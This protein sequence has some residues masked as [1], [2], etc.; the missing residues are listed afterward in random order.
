MEK[1]FLSYTYRPH[2]DHAEETERLQRYARRV[3]EAMGLRVIDGVDLGG[4]ALD[5]ALKERISDA[6]ALIAL[7]TP[8]ADQANQI[9]EPQFV[10]SEF[11]FADARQKPTLRI[12]H[13]ALQPRGLGAANEYFSFAAGRELDVVFKLMNTLAIWKRELG[14]AV[15]LR[16]EPQ[17]VAGRYDE[18]QGHEC[19]YQRI[20]TRGMEP[21][22]RAIVL[23]EP[24]AAYVYL[25]KIRTGE[26]VRVR[27]EVDG[28]RWLSKTPVD[29]FVGGISIEREP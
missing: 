20:T 28:E 12:I 7:M 27:L 24:G 14:E 1:V 17:D 2:P 15:R 22:Q 21:W 16:L 11:T 5:D 13:Q 26:R 19:E 23:A 29:P 9:D 6:D 25:P 18:T 10:A 8:Q 3:I 4:G